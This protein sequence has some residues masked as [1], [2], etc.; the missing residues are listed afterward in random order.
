MF[1]KAIELDP[2]YARRNGAEATYLVEWLYYWS[3]DPQI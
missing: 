1:E 3:R 2:Q